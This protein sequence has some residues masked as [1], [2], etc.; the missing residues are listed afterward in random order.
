[1]LKVSPDAGIE[2]ALDAPRHMRHGAIGGRQADRGPPP[3]PT[4]QISRMP[5]MK[6][7]APQTSAISMVCPKSGCST[8]TVTA[9]SSSPSAMVL[10]GIS[11]RRADS[12][13]SQAIRITKAGLRNSDGWMLTPS[14]TI[15]RRAPLTSAPKS[16]VPQHHQQA[17]DEDD[18]REPADHSAAAGTRSPSITASA[19]SR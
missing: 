3:S 1:M 2:E 7:S 15:Q 6:N 4:T 19:G 9:T 5:A 11:G 16:S 13:N 12:P 17:D 10:A 14:R 18:E 8:S